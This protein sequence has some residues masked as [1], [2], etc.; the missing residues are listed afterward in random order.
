MRVLKDGVM[1]NALVTVI[2]TPLH[3]VAGSTLDITF[4][5]IQYVVQQNLGVIVAD[6]LT[7]IF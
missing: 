7:V 5:F 6:L 2:V 4:D 1:D 3:G